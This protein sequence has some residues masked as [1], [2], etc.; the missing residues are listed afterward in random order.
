[1]EAWT[2]QGRSPGFAIAVLEAVGKSADDVGAAAALRRIA[3]RVPDWA[4][5]AQ[6]ALARTG[7]RDGQPPRPPG[8]RRDPSLGTSTWPRGRRRPP[9]VRAPSRTGTG[10]RAT[11]PA[12]TRWRAAGAAPRTGRPRPGWPSPSDPCGGMA[13]GLPAM[14]FAPVALPPSLRTL[15]AG[16]VLRQHRRTLDD[17]DRRVL[18]RADGHPDDW[19]PRD[20]RDA[21]S[22]PRDRPHFDVSRTVAGLDRPAGCDERGTNI[23]DPRAGRVPATS[24][25]Y[26]IGPSTSGSYPNLASFRTQRGAILPA[27]TS[28]MMMSTPSTIRPATRP[29]IKNRWRSSSRSSTSGPVLMAFALRGA[30]C[31]DWPHSTGPDRA[32]NEQDPTRVRFPDDEVTRLR[33]RM[34]VIVSPPC[35]PVVLK[36]D[37][38]RE[39]DAVLAQVGLGLRR[40]PGLAHPGDRSE[41]CSPR[42]HPALT[43][44]LTANLSQRARMIGRE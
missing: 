24:T 15:L 10:P 4:D 25:T 30:P 27:G 19:G 26:V 13:P 44:P 28:S 23:G 9:R 3:S 29:G 14:A 43:P 22:G 38:L 7:H 1:M 6:Q 31:G 2:D 35:R 40:I 11:T 33:R 34:L 42:P 21:P 12:A 37:G 17:C 5:I 16:R 18:E 41:G 20:H 36:R 39:S 8:S 32:R